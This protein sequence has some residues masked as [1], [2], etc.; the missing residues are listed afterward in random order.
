MFF[1]IFVIFFRILNFLNKFPICGKFFDASYSGAKV[2]Q[3]FGFSI[4]K[5]LVFAMKA[6]KSV[7]SGR[8]RWRW[9][10]AANYA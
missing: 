10:R 9:G 8:C 3:I 2:V 5:C 6:S 1:L 4:N 7:S